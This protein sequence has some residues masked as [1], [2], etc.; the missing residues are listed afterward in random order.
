MPMNRQYLKA[1]RKAMM[2]DSRKAVCFS[3]WNYLC[4]AGFA[5]SAVSLIG[6]LPGCVLSAVL[7]LAG[8]YQCKRKEECGTRVALCG[9]F[10]ALIGGA[11]SAATGAWKN[12]AANLAT[13]AFAYLVLSLILTMIL[14]G[15]MYAYYYLKKGG[16]HH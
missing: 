10:F 9:L 12:V 16:R 11:V 2:S 3:D 14:I 13:A 15:G 7:D 4:L 5:F 1:R 6:W 8:F